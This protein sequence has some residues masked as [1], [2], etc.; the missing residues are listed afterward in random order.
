MQL[1]SGKE[2][3]EMII[4]NVPFEGELSPGRMKTATSGLYGA[5]VVKRFKS[6]FSA[7]FFPFFGSAAPQAFFRPGHEFLG[8]PRAG[9][10][11]VGRR[12]DIN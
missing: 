1:T 7:L 10:V 8:R 9:A 12:T 3:E 4:F 6:I 2:P 11:K 5:F